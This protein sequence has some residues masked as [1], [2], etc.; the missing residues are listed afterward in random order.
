MATEF[1]ILGE[2]QVLQDGMPCALGPRRQRSLL[3]RLL[4]R[5]NQPIP[6][7]RLMDELWPD[8]D[9]EVA[10]HRLHVHISRLRAVLGAE[11]ERLASDASAYRLLVEPEALDASRFVA[12][13]ADG[14]RELADGDATKAA[15]RLRAALSLWRGPALVEFVDEPFACSEAARLDQLRL[16]VLEDRIN[17]DLSLGRHSE[18]IEDAVM[19]SPVALGMTRKRLELSKDRLGFLITRLVYQRPSLLVGRVLRRGQLRIA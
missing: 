18:L 13:A 10:R 15:E 19:E 6:I 1:G 17:A 9:P 4:V 12:L 3:A 11:R 7:E 16:A 14:R 8:E 2:L 5:A